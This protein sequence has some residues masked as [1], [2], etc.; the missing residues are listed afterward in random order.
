MLPP[1]LPVFPRSSLSAPG[2]LLSSVIQSSRLTSNPVVSASL[3]VNLVVRGERAGVLYGRTCWGG[4]GRAVRRGITVQAE[5]RWASAASVSTGPTATWN[6]RWS[7]PLQPSAS[8]PTTPSSTPS[9]APGSHA[10]RRLRRRGGLRRTHE[11]RLRLLWEGRCR[12]TVTSTPAAFRYLA[13]SEA[14]SGV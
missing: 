11:Q 2:E 5:R 6:A 9:P 1:A 14:S 12:G 3:T 8:S 10:A 13:W 4:R 7:V